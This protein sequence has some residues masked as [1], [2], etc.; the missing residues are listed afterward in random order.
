MVG[1]SM[2]TTRFRAVRVAEPSLPEESS[3]RT[4]IAVTAI[5][6]RKALAARGSAGIN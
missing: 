4:S 2:L 3:S 1:T 5:D 6:K